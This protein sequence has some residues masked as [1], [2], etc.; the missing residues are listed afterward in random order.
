M[1]QARGQAETCAQARMPVV[2]H[3]PVVLRRDLLCLA[4]VFCSCYLWV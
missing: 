2:L 1:L 4:T 3:M